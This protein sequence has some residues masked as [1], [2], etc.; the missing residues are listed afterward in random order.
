MEQRT[1]KTSI[2]F[3]SFNYKYIL[4]LIAALSFTSYARNAS[5]MSEPSSQTSTSASFNTCPLL[6]EI[7]HQ[8]AEMTEI[9]DAQFNSFPKIDLLATANIGLAENRRKCYNSYTVVLHQIF[10]P[11]GRTAA[12]RSTN[13]C[14][15]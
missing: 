14:V 5:P 2:N 4:Y 3:S 11:T 6:C 13:M 9:D 8:N 7:P 12:H 1:G 10:E 15:C